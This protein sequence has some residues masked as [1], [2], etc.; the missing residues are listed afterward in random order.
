MS[1]WFSNTMCR[2]TTATSSVVKARAMRPA[3]GSEWRSEPGHSIWKATST[4]TLPFSFLSDIGSGALNHCAVTSSG[5]VS[6][7]NWV[8]AM[9]RPFWGRG[10][11][12]LLAA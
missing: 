11:I 6:G 3:C 7:L 8:S 12:G 2:P 9:G 10:A 5:G 4:T 1:L